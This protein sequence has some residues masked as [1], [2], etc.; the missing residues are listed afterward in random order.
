MVDRAEAGLKGKDVEYYHWHVYEVE[1]SQNDTV[2]LP[3]FSTTENLKVAVINKKSD[4]SAVTCTYAANNVVTVTGAG[5]DMAC[6]LY[7]FGR[8]A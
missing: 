2:T 6:V 1:V 7:A 4:G 5:T 8:K 3:E